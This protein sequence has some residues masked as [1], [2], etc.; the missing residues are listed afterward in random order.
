MISQIIINSIYTGSIYALIAFG[1]TLI[2][3]TMNHFNMAYGATVMVAGY[4]FYCLYTLL[5]MPLFV[6]IILSCIVMTTFMIGVDRLCYYHF[7]KKRVPKWTTVVMSMSVATLL[8]AV[9]S[10][11][12]GNRAKV[13]YEGIPEIFR[14]GSFSVT[15]LQILVFTT[16]VAIM[17]AMSI[18]LRKTRYGK[19]IRAVANNKDM[20]LTVGVNVESV[21]LVVIALGTSLAT[22]AGCFM[23]MDSGIRPMMASTALLKAICTS[24]VGGVGNIKGALIAAFIFGFIE[25]FSVLYIGGGWRDALPIV[26]I[27]VMMLIRPAA[28][29][30]TDNS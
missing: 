6:S 11:I 4:V 29:G 17:L 30:I 28:F 21:F 26:I 23:S 12:F 14:V 19:L 15:S 3:S 16:A 20:A 22:C 13:V 5:K 10:I 1:F 24:I 2:Y 9:M 8:G 25:N 7:R 27:V 18:L